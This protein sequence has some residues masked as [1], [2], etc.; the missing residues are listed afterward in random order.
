MAALLI[1]IL[2]LLLACSLL[3]EGGGR[4][5][6]LLHALELREYGGESLSSIADLDMPSIGEIQYID[7]DDYR[8]TI[9]GCVT[10][11]RSYTYSEVVDNF[12][13]HGAIAPIYLMDG[14]N[15]TI[16]WEGVLVA[17]LIQAAGQRD[18]ANTVIFHARDGYST[19]LPLAYIIEND[20]IMAYRA[21][22]VTLPADLGFPFI[23]VAKGKWGY[24]WIRWITFIEV[25]DNDGY[26]GYWESRGCS[27]EGDVEVGNGT[28]CRADDRDADPPAGG[29][30]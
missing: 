22:G 7:R 13:A 14:R 8:L 20:I 25:S 19:S 24:K 26:R 5:S 28:L 9:G 29:I 17:D 23:L 27:N 11:P 2:A 12:T 6:P 16:Y 10:A 30:S 3:A 4:T 21:N 1:F 18:G 15:A